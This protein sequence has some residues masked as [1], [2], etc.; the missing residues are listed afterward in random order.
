MS[1]YCAISRAP[2]LEHDEIRVLFGESKTPTTPIIPVGHNASN[3]FTFFGLSIPA[4]YSDFEIRLN[5]NLYRDD[6]FSSYL[7]N[8]NHTKVDNTLNT[9]DDFIKQVKTEFNLDHRV[10]FTFILESVYQEMTKK[11]NF[12][13]SSGQKVSSITDTLDDFSSIFNTVEYHKHLDINEERKNSII[14]NFKKKKEKPKNKS[15]KSYLNFFKTPEDYLKEMFLFRETVEAFSFKP[16]NEFFKSI[17]YHL[18]YSVADFQIKANNERLLSLLIVDSAFSQSLK[19]Y[20]I[21]LT[22]AVFS[23][24]VKTVDNYDFQQAITNICKKQKEKI[25]TYSV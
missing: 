9:L 22:P 3:F 1:Y 21:V 8:Q 4:I 2:I 25:E 10:T 24:P 15:E 7:H 13:S 5:K 23:N 17:S 14:S 20:N 19:R 16:I 12:N 6:D 18:F 11:I